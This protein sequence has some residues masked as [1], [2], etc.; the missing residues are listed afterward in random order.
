MPTKV[1][2]P[3]VPKT[4]KAPKAEKGAI[5]VPVFSPKGAELA[6]IT[7][8]EALFGVAYNKTLVALA[9]RVYRANQREGSACTKTR[10]EVEGSTRKIYRQK[11]TGRARHGGIRAPFFVGGGIAF[12]PKPRDYRMG[13]TKAMKHKAL[14]SAIS[15]VVKQKTMKV[16]DG[17]DTLELKT[18]A[19]ATMMQ[20]LGITKRALYVVGKDSQKTMRAAR[21]IATVDVEPYSNL[22][23]YDLVT[24]GTI[25]FTK[26]ALTGFIEQYQK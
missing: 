20:T 10:S 11:G 7:V 15:F 26:D 5:T 22:T 8:P 17:V 14:L 13:I 23:V 16:V 24:H 12:G 25:L 4:P 18:K 9:M 21:N 1:S 2:T 19:F 3:K 6:S